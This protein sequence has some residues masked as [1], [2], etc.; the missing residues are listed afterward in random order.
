[1]EKNIKS[2]L[3]LMLAFVMVFGLIPA[4]VFATGAELA[5]AEPA[6]EITADG[7]NV[8]KIGDAE[9]ATLAA[10]IAAVQNGETIV[11]LAD[12]A[13]DVTITQ[14]KNVAFTIDGD[15][16]TLAGTMNINGTHYAG[17]QGQGLT[18]QNLKFIVDDYGIYAYNNKAKYARNV[19]VDGCTFE[20]AAGGKTGYGF[21][22]RNVYNFTVKS[23][24]GTGLFDFFYA[25]GSID[26]LDVENVTITDTENAF[27]LAYGNKLNFTNVTTSNVDF[28]ISIKNQTKNGTATI[29]D[30]NLSGDNAVFLIVVDPTYN[31]NLIFTGNTLVD[32]ENWLVVADNDG[33]IITGEEGNPFNVQKN[34]D[35]DAEEDVTIVIPVPNVAEVNG[36]GYTTLTDAIAA[37]NAGDT[38]TFLADITEDVTLNKKVTI[39]GAD[40]SYTGKMTVNTSLTVTVQNVN[41]VKGYIDE[42]NGSKGTLTVKNCKFDGTGT[43]Y[44][45]AITMRGGDKVVVE[46]CQSEGFV[47]GFLYT[48]KSVTNVSVKDVTV[49]NCDMGL[50]FTYANKI[51]LENVILDLS[52][53]GY[54]IQT[55]NYGAKTLTLNNCE[56]SG[57]YAIYVWERTANSVVDTFVFQGTG[58]KLSGEVATNGHA[59]LKLADIDATLTAPEGL[60][61]TVDADEGY[62]VIYEEG[63]YKVVYKVD[64]AEVNGVGYTTLAAAIAAANA[65]DTIILLDNITE[66][67]T[68]NKNVTI[69]GADFSYT[70]MMKVNSGL[71]VTVQNVNFVN[72]C[73]DKVKGTKGTLTV[74]DCTFDGTGS[75]YYYAVTMRGGAKVVTENCQSKGFV[76][77]FLYIPNSVTNVSVK[78]VAVTECGMGINV[79]YGN[80]VTLENVTM[81][82]VG[83][84]IQSHNY[85]AKTFTMNNCDIS[86]EYAIFAWE[87]TENAVVDTFVFQGTGNKLSGEVVTNG[88]AVLK[89]ADID[90]TLTAPEGLT[91][92]TDAGEQ[93]KV[94]YE[95]GVYKVALKVY[96]AEV[97]GEQYES[98]QEA[99]NA[100]NSGDTVLVTADHEIA[101]D[102]DPLINVIGKD[103]TIDLNG[104]TVITNAASAEQVVRIVF[105]TA[106][107][108]KLTVL[109]SV[110]TGTVI[111]NGEGVLHYMFRNEG[112]MTIK[113]G[114]YELSAFEGGAMFFATNSN[115][116]VEGGN[117]KQ[118][119]AGWMFNTLGNGAGNVI[120]VTGGTFNRYFIGGEAFNENLWN[121]VV[122]PSIYALSDNGDGT[123]TIKDAVCFDNYTGFGYE[124]LAEAIAVT[125]SITLVADVAEDAELTKSITLELGG[126]TYSGTVTLTA[127]DVTLTA[128][129]GLNVITN[130]DEHKVVY[131]D[132]VYM[133][134]PKV[135]VAEVNGEVFESIQEAVNAANDGD[136]VL[137]IADHEIACDAEILINVVGKDITI[138]LN[139]KAVT[140]NAGAEQA[141]RVVFRTEADAKL[142]I[143]DSVGTGS[144][145][146][147]GEGVLHYMFRNEGEMIV[148][149]GSYEL[150]ALS[151]GAMFFSTNNNMLVEG[152]NFKQTTEGWMFNAIGNGSNVI[153]AIGGTFNRY[154]IGGEAF[155]EN[156]WNEVVIPYIYALSD[157]GDGT[158]TITDAVCYNTNTGFGYA[159][160][161]EAAA[162][163]KDG[164]NIVLLADIAENVV[165]DGKSISL[166]LNRMYMTGEI[167]LA[168]ADAALTAAKDLNVVT[169]VADAKVV[170]ENGTYMVKLLQYVA[171]IGETKYDD[172]SDALAAAKSGETVQVIANTAE[173]LVMVPAEVK[174]DLNG[175]VVTAKNVLAF[176]IVMDTASEVGGIKISNDTTTAFTKLQPEN[177][178]YLPIY[179]TR[180]GMY[181]FFEHEV[182]AVDVVAGEDDAK[183]RFQLRFE[184]KAAYEVLANTADSDVSYVLNLM[185]TGMEDYTVRYRM[186]DATV[187]AY[188]A[189]VYEQMSD[190]ENP[191][192][193]RKMTLTIYGVNALGTGGYV[194][195]VPSVETVAEV[196]STADMLRHEN[197]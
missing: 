174:L 58:N 72:G 54:G 28:G 49:T 119:T 163:A 116:L 105:R 143:Q 138:D 56:I 63:V 151:G 89:L 180:D 150:S 158:W 91:V 155:N 170:Y 93:Y 171:Q 110:G 33:N 73:I 183:F 57:Q 115:M 124:T 134:T 43:S 114:N 48:P 135:Y 6:V 75:D 17:N 15:G 145:I 173:F 162:A 81:T 107:D 50:N 147:N 121:E 70:G 148:K 11:L 14:K 46:G 125:D 185:W 31:Y 190:A 176:G 12:V 52:D 113:S 36:V 127:I 39:D 157:N 55:H 177:G 132:G 5:A 101:C 195:A 76:Y 144:V 142:T 152:G 47:Y 65:G 35:E 149:S 34:G 78:N 197:P 154:F 141:A 90:A 172:L 2:F 61:V 193:T 178:G 136:T 86:G 80:K 32:S 120:T 104:K 53:A 8:A 92:T 85:G 51:T 111:A 194:S 83:Y 181:K 140:I 25:G 84:G 186:T 66:N 45:Y 196:T 165:I 160:L 133:V 164:E 21:A 24:S 159:S 22:V 182:V 82:G 192:N 117:F 4:N 139:G 191:E 175:F 189:S 103:I 23:T 37:A 100:A 96:V 128:A 41:F 95:E 59:V 153:T 184:D 29:T 108:A 40:F 118:N 69:E 30:C 168:S 38:I 10:A 188:A 123:W 44:Y 19:T 16:H 106:A 167:T 122:I 99:V 42:A 112:E 88:H 137:V 94:I 74:K 129:E 64:V 126:C 20:S 161:N 131:V 98:I 156:L 62:K 187:R 87:R 1:M 130:V 102:A 13:G 26:G 179:D 71:T 67:V 146:A 9:Y 60:T 68:V 166:E 109:D 169:S 27:F 7:G 79:A 77:G 97:N 3:S 18:I